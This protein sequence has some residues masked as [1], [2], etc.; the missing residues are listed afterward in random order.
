MQ[1]PSVVLEN[2]PIRVE[3]QG[4][5]SDTHRLQQAGWQMAMYHEPQHMRD[6]FVF[7]NEAMKIRGVS[8]GYD[9]YHVLDGRNRNGKFDADRVPPI[10]INCL[11]D[12]RA[13]YVQLD[14]DIMK[15]RQIDCQPRM[16]ESSEVQWDSLFGI[17]PNCN[18]SMFV[19]K[20]DMDVVDHLQAIIDKQR[21]KQAELREKHRKRHKGE[22]VITNS[23]SDILLQVRAA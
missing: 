18:E 8:H 7:S 10:I 23:V 6:Y 14:F 4:W 1:R 9:R 21:P 5:S 3:F 16:I 15:A 22:A 17:V 19:D 13:T 2:Q 11:G 20:A 12:L